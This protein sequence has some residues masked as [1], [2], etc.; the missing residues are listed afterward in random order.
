[1][2]KNEIKKILIDNG[3]NEEKLANKRLKDLKILLEDLEKMQDKEN[4]LVLN[5]VIPNEEIDNNENLSEKQIPSQTDPNWTQFVMGHFSDDEL[6]GENPR[7]EGLRRVSELLI[8]TIMEEG[9]HLISSPGPDNDYRA[10]VKA[11]VVFHSHDGL[12]KRFEA[13]ADAYTGNCQ[14]DFSIYPTA[15]ADTRAKG[16]CYRSALKLKRIIAAEEAIGPVDAIENIANEKIKT[17]QITAIRLLA[18][19]S[20]IS[21]IKLLDSL[22]I[23]YDKLSNGFAKLES[24]LYSDALITIKRLNEIRSS[25]NIPDNIKI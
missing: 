12:N 9:C 17:G 13:L 3:Y 4:I 2:K 11:W 8:G 20:N 16:R 10:C 24:L 1:M 15:M 7:L 23:T 6:E 5:N 21:I 18:D 19:R 25:N 14:Q 22:G